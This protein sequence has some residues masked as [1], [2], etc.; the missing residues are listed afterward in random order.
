MTDTR[1]PLRQQ[2]LI[3]RNRHL[4]PRAW[5]LRYWRDA[6]WAFRTFVAP[7]VARRLRFVRR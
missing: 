7:K 6:P 1:P 5:W 4:I 2:G 3:E